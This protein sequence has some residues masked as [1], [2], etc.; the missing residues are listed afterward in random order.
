MR[1]LL[2]TCVLYPTVMREV[3]L[4]AARAGL[5]TPLW[6]ERIIEEWRRAAANKKDG[7]AD[8]AAVEIALTQ[9]A[10][11][12]AQMDYAVPQGTELWLPDADDVHVLAAAIN[13]R[14]DQLVTAN[15]KDFP[16]RVLSKHNIIRRDPDGFLLELAHAH[17]DKMDA[18][19]AAVLAQA[20]KM[21]DAP[22]TARALLKKT[23]LPRLGKHIEAQ[24]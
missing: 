5:F 19:V 11:P 2:D 6:S 23:R 16:T 21:A 14:A 8:Q 7:F 9:S 18:V 10:W 4:G 12:K 15:V 22:Y 17:A 13:G 3:L 1:V 20:N 24:A